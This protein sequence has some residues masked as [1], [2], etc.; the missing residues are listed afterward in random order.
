MKKVL[1]VDSSANMRNKLK[2]L[3]QKHGFEVVGEAEDGRIAVKKFKELTPDIVTMELDLP[4]M[5]GLE[6]LKAIRQM[7]PDAKVAIITSQDCSKT[8][9]TVSALGAK[10]YLL[11]SF[12][13]ERI[14]QALKAL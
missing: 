5:D 7:D 9:R 14:I 3:L 11:K 13:R 12:S 6:A 1:I 4:L 8:I 2:M 10:E